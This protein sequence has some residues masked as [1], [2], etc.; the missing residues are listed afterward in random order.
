MNVFGKKSF[1][2]TN[3]VVLVKTPWDPDLPPVTHRVDSFSITTLA[4]A[5]LG[6]NKLVAI[7]V[8]PTNFFFVKS[9]YQLECILR[10]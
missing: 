2:L 6:S 4:P 10:K 3:S 5:N 7:S 9:K 8:S 1:N